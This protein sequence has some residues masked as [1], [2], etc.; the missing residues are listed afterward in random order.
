MSTVPSTSVSQSNFASIFNAALNAYKRKTKKDLASHPLLPRLQSCNSPDAILTVLHE[1][2]PTF[3]QS[4]NGVTRW[5]MPTVKVLFAFSAA[6]GQGVGQVDIRIVLGEE[7]LFSYPFSGIP[8]GECYICRDRRSPLGWSRSCLPSAADFYTLASQAAK[9]DGSSRDKLIDAFNR[10]E[11]FFRRLETYISIKPSMAMTNMIVEIMVEVLNILALATKEVKRERLSEFLLHKFTIFYS[12]FYLEKFF[13]RL[14][15]N[16][17]LE[18]SLQRLDRL[19]QEEALMASTAQ[20]EMA[21]DINDRVAS[22]QGEVQGTRGGVQIV[23]GDVQGVGHGVQAIDDRVRGIDTEVKNISSKVQGVNDKINRSLSFKSHSDGSNF[24]TGNQLRNSFLR[25]L[26]P[27]DQSTN[28]NVVCKSRHKGTAQWFFQ[29]DIFKEWK[30][31]G[32]FLWI[33][34]K[35]ASLLAFNIRWPLIVFRFYYSRCRE[36]CTLVRPPLALFTVVKL[37][38]SI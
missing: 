10:I 9:D 6:V 20:L 31:T 33:N 8:T 23:R 18:D 11:H 28:H 4:E 2:I 19:T 25:W 5:V 26:S 3:S 12:Y 1:E 17:D 21:Q 14:V 15:G 37:T 16:T 24:F 35:R 29:G 30:S 22:V 13:K 34:G 27:P 32:S 7:F 36:N 38:L